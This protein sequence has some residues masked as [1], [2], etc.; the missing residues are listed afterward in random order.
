MLLQTIILYLTDSRLCAVLILLHCVLPPTRPTVGY[1]PTVSSAQEETIIFAQTPQEAKQKLHDLL[2][3]YSDLGLKPA[4]KLIAI[5]TN[6]KDLLGSFFVCYN[7]LCYNLSSMK[8]AVDVYIKLALVLGLQHSKISKLVWLFVVRYVYGVYVPEK[9]SNIEKLV[10]YLS[11][12]R[13]V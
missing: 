10:V 12:T 11:N 7:D 1:K 2:A 3:R 9:Y 6:Y 8:R 5:G 4:P 13:H